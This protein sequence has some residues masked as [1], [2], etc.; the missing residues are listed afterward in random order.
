M[1]FTNKTR[2]TMFNTIRKKKN[3]IEKR[4]IMFIRKEAIQILIN[5]ENT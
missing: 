2:T 5:K 1:L 4:A 3:Q